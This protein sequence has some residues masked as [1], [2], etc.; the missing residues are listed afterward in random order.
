[1]VNAI[2]SITKCSTLTA[3]TVSNCNPFQ[4]HQEVSAPVVGHLTLGYAPT[5]GKQSHDNFGSR[6][7]NLASSLPLEDLNE[8]ELTASHRLDLHC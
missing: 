6:C 5:K 3:V 1:M 8:S 7:G 4:T 2:E